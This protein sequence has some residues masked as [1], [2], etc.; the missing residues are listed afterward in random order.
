[1]YRRDVVFREMKDDVKHKVLQIKEE[2]EKVKFDL[3]DDE[4]DSKEEQES[5]EEDHH[6]LVLRRSVR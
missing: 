3:M 5:K 2:Q 4:S 1:M 6:T